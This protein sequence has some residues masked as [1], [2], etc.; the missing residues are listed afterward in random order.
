MRPTAIDIQRLY[1]FDV[2]S[3]RPF[4][5]S[6]RAFFAA[7]EA[8]PTVLRIHDAARTA[9]HP[10]EM[11]SLLLCEEAGYLAPR[12]FKTATGDVLFPW[13][14]G[15]GYMTSWIEGEEP[16]GSVDDAC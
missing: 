1:G 8:G 10:G 11:R 2:R 4:G 14:D 12:L 5:D 16:A 15:E 9:A 3:I 6:T 13:E 7:T